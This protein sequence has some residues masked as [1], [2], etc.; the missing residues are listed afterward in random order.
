MY[1]SG[2]ITNVDTDTAIIFVLACEIYMYDFRIFFL[3]DEIYLYDVQVFL[4]A[5]TLERYNDVS[6]ITMRD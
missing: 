5:G 6:A 2:A 3:V 4:G 1:T